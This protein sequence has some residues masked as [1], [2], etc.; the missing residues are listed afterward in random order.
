MP[1]THN[2][3]PRAVCS[4]TPEVR[5]EKTWLLDMVA[6]AILLVHGMMRSPTT[7][8]TILV[9]LYHR[10]VE[11]WLTVSRNPLVISLKLSG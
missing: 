3:M 9:S 2:K 6:L 11:C 4:N 7:T 8:S 5:M 10:L 1:I